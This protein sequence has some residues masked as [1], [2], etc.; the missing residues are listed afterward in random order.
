MKGA[1]MRLY[2]RTSLPA[3]ISVKSVVTA[4]RARPVKCDPGA[5]VH[6]FWE[7]AFTKSGTHSVTVDGKTL[8]V[9][10]GSCT[11]YPPLAPHS[12]KRFGDT[13]LEIIS[14]ESDSEILPKLSHRV[15][16]LND[17]EI[18]MINDIIDLAALNMESVNGEEKLVGMRARDGA[19]A[20]QLQILKNKI[21]I[22]IISIHTREGGSMGS[23]KRGYK[24]EYADTLTKFLRMNIGKKLSL[25]DM[26]KEL[27]I[28]T[29][30]LKVISR[31]VLRASPMDYF[32]SLKIEAAMKL[33][34]ESELS[35]TE[36]SERLG[37]SSIHYFS[38]LFKNR[39]GMTPSEYAK[40]KI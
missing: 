5:D 6:D 8:D 3:L 7:L 27:S 20:A 1:K 25:S 35:F 34:R 4:F 39:T 33:M 14:F 18:E 17:D 28:S 24:R 15:L 11:I 30:R 37:F 38:K 13:V 36:I 19:S 21:E 12:G 29:S 40:M 9:P 22:L 10:E 2:Q 32:I 26:A 23:S 31:E 16:Q